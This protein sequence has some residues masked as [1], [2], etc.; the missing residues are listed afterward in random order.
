MAQ[1]PL[2]FGEA[3]KRPAWDDLGA[4]GTPAPAPTRWSQF[5][6]AYP[7]YN[8]VPDPDMAEWL[9]GKFYADMD[10]TAYYEALGRPELGLDPDDMDPRNPAWESDNLPGTA[11]SRMAKAGIE[12]L[13]AAWNKPDFGRLS[14]ESQAGLDSVIGK[15]RSNNPLDARNLQS[16]VANAGAGILDVLDVPWS[17]LVGAAGQGGQEIE[18]QIRGENY[19]PMLAREPEGFA[20]LKELADVGGAAAGTGARGG[21]RPRV[22]APEALGKPTTPA[23][24]LREG[25]DIGQDGRIAAADALVEEARKNGTPVTRDQVA[26]LFGADVGETP[27]ALDQVPVRDPLRDA[28]GQWNPIER[29]DAPA[30]DAL[31]ARRRSLMEDMGMA[32]DALRAEGAPLDTVLRTARPDSWDEMSGVARPPKQLDEAALAEQEAARQARR[33]DLAARRSQAQDAIRMEAEAE[34]PAAQLEDLYM[35]DQPPPGEAIGSFEVKPSRIRKEDM[36]A[37]YPL[38]SALSPAREITTATG[39]KVWHRGPMDLVTWLRSEGGL[40]EDRGELAAM[41][42]NNKGRDGVPFTGNERFM[43]RIVNPN[44][45]NLD[46][47]ARHAWESGM[48]PQFTER[49]TINQFLDVLRETWDGRPGRVFRPGDAEEIRILR[50]RSALDGAITEMGGD[51]RKMTERQ[52]MAAVER[53]RFADEEARAQQIPFD[54]RTDAQREAPLPAQAERDLADFADVRLHREGRGPAPKVDLSPDAVRAVTVSLRSELD[55]LNLKDV[56]LEVGETVDGKGGWYRPGVI[57]VAANAARGADWVL[58]HEVMHAID[59]MGVTRPGERAALN[60]AVRRRKGLMADIEARYPD[61]SPENRLREAVADLHANWKRGDYKAKGIVEAAFKRIGQFVEALTNALRG[62]GFISAQGVMERIQSGEVGARP[63]DGS[64]GLTAAHMNRAEPGLDGPHDPLEAVRRASGTS[65]N[66][67]GRDA[68]FDAAQQAGMPNAADNN[69]WLRR[70]P[71]IGDALKAYTAKVGGP[72]AEKLEH[73]A[74][75]DVPLF[76]PLR[77]MGMVPDRDAYL[78]MRG[79]AQG[80]DTRL[81]NAAENVHKVLDTGSKAE[82]AAIYEYMTT[83][84]ADPSSI[85][86]PKRRELAIR[87]KAAVDEIGQELVRGNWLP[88]EVVAAN[89]GE[90]LPRLYLQYVL[91]PEGSFAGSGKRLSDGGH[92]KARKDIPQEQRELLGEIKDPGFLASRALLVARD[93][94]LDNFLR[95]IAANKAWVNPASRIEFEGKIVSA[96]WLDEQAK[97]HAEIA[98]AQT[99][100]TSKA[101]NERKSLSMRAAVE[102]AKR[103]NPAA[104]PSLYAEVPNNKRYGA[105]MGLEVRKDI[106]DDIVGVVDYAAEQSGIQKAL[107]RDSALG[108]TT[109]VIKASKTAWNLPGQARNFMG[110]SIQANVLGEISIAMLPVRFSQAVRDYRRKGP[111]YQEVLDNGVLSSTLTNNEVMKFRD[112][113]SAVDRELMGGTGLDAVKRAAMVPL[114]GAAK[115]ANFATDAYQLNEVLWKMAVVIDQKAKGANTVQAVSKAKDAIFDYSLVPPSIEFLRSNPVTGA[116]FLTFLYKSTGALIETALRKPE[117]FAPY[118]ALA[119]G[120]K[121]LVTESMD[122]TDDEFDAY[123]EMLP[124][125]ARREGTT[126]LVP[127]KD[128]QGRVQ[129]VDV[130]YIF[131]WGSQIKTVNNLRAVSADGDATGVLRQAADGLPLLS[132]PLVDVL[133]ALR[134]NIDPFTGRPVYNEYD[135]PAT[136]LG[137]ATGYMVKQ[138]IRPWLSDRGAAERALDTVNGQLDRNGEPG[139]TPAQA[140]LRFAGIN[141]NPFDP[142]KQGPRQAYYD[143][144]D[145]R[146]SIERARSMLRNQGLTPEDRDRKMQEYRQFIDEKARKAD[147]RRARMGL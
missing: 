43:G 124:D 138:F 12:G 94:V 137:D 110:G 65:E 50:E 127:W 121:A 9:R 75:K 133:T 119:A 111:V 63:R 132:M 90:Y 19:K 131:P 86:T 2:K 71:V 41:G 125:Y 4:P 47:A 56:R 73:L 126:A 130:G 135:P 108:K 62:N 114:H 37:E 6:S 67:G 14:D 72:A 78:A 93:F 30:L 53:K 81:K 44:G 147:E 134:T 52:M 3:I 54:T 82:R 129:P 83:R 76:G 113:A 79:V 95:E 103:A 105:L 61:L 18:R 57:R 74:G 10:K 24:L 91:D 39:R 142:A 31:L 15:Q 38:S 25:P 16:G 51:P 69:T 115:V 118:I 146:H 92:L 122:V 84:D 136:R 128:D 141:I 87:A 77:S 5:R 40:R 98:A 116:P 101:A 20:A 109:R 48:L 59:D 96:R 42:I 46:D 29:G 139:L 58:D 89:R 117:R 100:P 17:G 80:L 85:P 120:W 112:Y 99:D 45:R 102:E 8:D 104:D 140:M 21:M 60:R 22:D 32:P 33:D 1:R 27:R 97:R 35:R 23:E 28:A 11:V 55:R 70:T 144:L 26:R 106:R 123:M 88:A 145:V 66:I 143:Q 36:G 64:M 7:E 49:P 13:K 34:L 68:L 107:G